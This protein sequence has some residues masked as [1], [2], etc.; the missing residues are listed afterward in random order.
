MTWSIKKII[1]DDG[2]KEVIGPFLLSRALILAVGYLSSLVIAKG[3]WFGAP[4]IG[5]SPLDLFFRWDCGWYLTIVMKGY[6]YI[7]GRESSV[8]FFPLYPLLV[9]LLSVSS[10]DV[11]IIK[12]TGLLISN[13]ALLLAS[14]YLYKLVVMNYKNQEV[15]FKTVFFMLISPMSFFFSVFYTEGLFLLL[16]ISSVYYASKRRW[17]EAS[18][19]GFLSSLTRLLGVLLIIPLLVEYLDITLRGKEIRI[20]R[21]RR[22]ILYLLAVPLGLLSYMT[23]LHYRFGD[24]FAF[25]HAIMAWSRSLASITTT[26]N[27]L[28]HYGLFYQVLFVGFASVAALLALYLVYSRMRLSHIAYAVVLLTASLSGNLLDSI[29]RYVSVIFP[30]YIGLALLASRRKFIDYSI[31]IGSVM[32]LTLFTILFTNGYWLT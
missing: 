1:N 24:A 27:S 10:S 28:N 12:I 5:G 29:P 25:M 15:A 30:L 16:T 8:A 20:R 21:I 9:K 11:T 14:I 13:V 7:P 23:Y 2:L 26:L 22:D 6:S 18:V 31:T 32:L 3:K 19:L 4:N 17:L